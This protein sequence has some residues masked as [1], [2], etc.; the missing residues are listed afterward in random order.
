MLILNMLD[1][2]KIEIHE[3]TILVGFNNA[4]RTD[5]PNERLFYLQ[6]M[7][8]GNVQD[9]FENEGSAMATSDERLGI[10]G[11]LLSH[12]MF[13]IGEDSDANVYL[14]SAVNSISV[15]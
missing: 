9:D 2:E 13:S 4:P 11:F 12:D 8:I 5:K 10:G 6:Q 3:D 1:G 15:I 14:T 7:Y